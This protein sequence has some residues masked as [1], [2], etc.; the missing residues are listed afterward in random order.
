MNEISWKFLEV[1]VNLDYFNDKKQ[2]KY[3]NI[4]AKIAIKYV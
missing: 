4:Y 3:W 1:N 2:I